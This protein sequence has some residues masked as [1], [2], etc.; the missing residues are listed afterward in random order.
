VILFVVTGAIIS[1][2]CESL[3]RGLATPSLTDERRASGP[4]SRREIEELFAI[5]SRNIQ[6]IFWMTD[7]KLDQLL[8]ISPGL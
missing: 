4:R 5:W 3:H 6:E 7:A 2:L 8:F 1:G